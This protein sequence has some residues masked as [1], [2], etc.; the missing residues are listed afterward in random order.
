MNHDALSPGYGPPRIDLIISL[1]RDQP[2]S[3]RAEFRRENIGN[4]PVPAIMM[5]IADNLEKRLRYVVEAMREANYPGERPVLYL[6]DK[7][8]P[9]ANGRA[10]Q[11]G[12]KAYTLQVPLEDGRLL[13]VT[14]G[15][16]GFDNVTSTLMDMLTGAPGYDDGSIPQ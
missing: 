7:S 14:L 4:E 15:Q 13:N 2:D 6:R 5:V 8:H 9:Q 1:I 10:A 3:T 11:T 16:E 12:E